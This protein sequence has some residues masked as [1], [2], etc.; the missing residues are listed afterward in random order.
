LCLWSLHGR[1]GHEFAHLGVDPANPASYRPEVLWYFGHL[2]LL[3]P[4][5]ARE[6]LRDVDLGSEMEILSYHVIDLARR[7]FRKHRWV[8]A[9]WASTAIAL[10]AIV[11]AG[12]S[13][14]VHAQF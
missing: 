13:L 10:L 1:V 9:G 11:A 2:A 8:N 3:E 7:V 5:A 12:T 4:D 14:F 6:R